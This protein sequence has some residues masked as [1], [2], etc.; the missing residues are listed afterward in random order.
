MHMRT[1]ESQFAQNEHRLEHLPAIEA[2][3]RFGQR[4]P[5]G[6]PV[7]KEWAQYS[8]GRTYAPNLT[9]YRD[10]FGKARRRRNKAEVESVGWAQRAGNGQQQSTVA[11]LGVVGLL[12][13]IGAF[14]AV[15]QV[16]Q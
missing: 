15:N 12:R 7:P 2:D 16:L 3:F 11:L 13:D 6:L 1:R 4:G 5:T 14:L 9:V 10:S 8:K